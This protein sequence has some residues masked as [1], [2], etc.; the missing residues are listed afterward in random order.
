MCACWYNAADPCMF[1][2]FYCAKGSACESLIQLYCTCTIQ[3]CCF[4]KVL[5]SEIVVL[6][7]PKKSASWEL[8]VSDVRPKGKRV[9]VNCHW[10]R[11]SCL[12]KQRGALRMQLGHPYFEL[13]DFC[14][15]REILT[16][17]IYLSDNWPRRE[18][19]QF[20]VEGIICVQCLITVSINLITFD[21]KL[22]FS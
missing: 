22:Y 6:F 7:A 1:S 4:W 2:G 13:P 9:A 21:G 5:S 19:F 11:Q 10:A 8:A 12:A 17:K 14:S 3:Y 15:W 16:V 18:I 20:F